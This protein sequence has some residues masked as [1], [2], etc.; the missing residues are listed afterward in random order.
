MAV[1]FVSR[2][3]LNPQDVDAEGKFYPAP[4][5]IA[6]I[7]VNQ[8]A[9]DISQSTTLTATEII[10][11]IQS[12]LTTVPK[13][14]LLG[15]KVRLDNFGI[16]KLGFKNKAECKGYDKA[17]LVTANDIDGLRVMYTPDSMLKAKLNKPEYVKLDARFIDKDETETPAESG[18]DSDAGN[19]D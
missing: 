18:T 17:N 12:L 1:P 13:Y 3:R 2:K 15:Y 7:G 5:Y 9:E 4:A 16:F 11:V 10:G 8:L 6:E 19:G 14:M